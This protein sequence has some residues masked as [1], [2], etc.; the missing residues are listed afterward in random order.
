MG[1]ACSA[2]VTGHAPW[3]DCVRRIKLEFNR[4]L[5]E[6]VRL[7]GAEIARIA[8][9]NVRISKIIFQLKLTEE[10]IQ[11]SLGVAEEPERLLTVEVGGARPR[12]PFASPL[13]PSLPPSLSLF[14]PPYLPLL[15]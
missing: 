6:V 2:D 13:P 12:D 15:G 3:Q 7:K 5:D 1:G 9:K 10:L 8:E 11:P 14:L 4:E